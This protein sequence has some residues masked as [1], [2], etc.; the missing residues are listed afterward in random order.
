MSEGEKPYFAPYF[1]RVKLSHSKM[2][3]DII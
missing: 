1:L 2:Q 3:G